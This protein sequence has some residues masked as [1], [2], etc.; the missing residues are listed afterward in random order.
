MSNAHAVWTD[1]TEIDRYHPIMRALH[2]ITVLLLLVIFVTGGWIVYFDPGHVPLKDRLYNLHQSTGILVWVLVLL[3]IVVR[4]ITGAPKLAP[5]VPMT[6]RMVASLNQ[7]AMYL[8]LV[9]QPIIGLADTNAWG[10]PL[11]WFEL[12]PVPSPNGKLAEA[13]AQTLSEIHW[14]G[15][16]TL[17]LLLTMHI[18]GAFYHGVI[19]RDGTLRHML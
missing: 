17:V 12:F 19:R 10:F 1:G 11:R 14:W 16:A 8:V 5:D 18:G 7:A 3:R 6:I 2:W 13:A 15:A 4:L 9:S